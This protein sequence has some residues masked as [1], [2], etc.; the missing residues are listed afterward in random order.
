MKWPVV[1]PLGSE[2]LL[3]VEDWTLDLKRADPANEKRFTFTVNGSKTGADGE[4]RS[5]QKFISNSGRIV[6][7]PEDW[8]AAYALALAGITPVPESFTVKWSVVP[9][10][11]D[12][13]TSPGVK[14]PAIET[15]VTLAQGLANSKHTLEIDGGAETIAALRVYRP[16]LQA[17]ET[18]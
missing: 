8:N 5:D 11:V 12:E 9:R 4:G 13:F 14:D 17:V 10:F 2:K 3:L 15:T 16:A 7:T 6:I 18:K 1:E